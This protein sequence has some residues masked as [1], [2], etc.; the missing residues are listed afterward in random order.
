MAGT[1]FP[2]VSS[3]AQEQEGGEEGGI[4]EVGQPGSCPAK[5]L[6]VSDGCTV[7]CSGADAREAGAEG[8]Q[9]GCP[10]RGV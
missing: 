9:H 1:G 2:F 10:G 8:G 5:T 6:L 7:S 3:D 4:S